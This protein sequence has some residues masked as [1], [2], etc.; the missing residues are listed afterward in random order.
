MGTDDLVSADVGHRNAGYPLSRSR[1]QRAV[2]SL[3]SYRQVSNR[4]P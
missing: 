3:G 2:Q 1:A 4:L